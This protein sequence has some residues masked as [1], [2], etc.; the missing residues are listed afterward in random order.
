VES[1]SGTPSQRRCRITLDSLAESF[2]LVSDEMTRE[3]E[4][5]YESLPDLLE[6]ASDEEQRAAL[7]AALENEGLPGRLRERACE[8]LANKNIELIGGAS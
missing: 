6:K 5:V 7:V 2:D 8:W 3:L 4:R 1:T